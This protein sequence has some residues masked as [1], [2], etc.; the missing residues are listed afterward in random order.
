MSREIGTIKDSGSRGVDL[1][2]TRYYGG[3]K[4][5][6]CL[7][8]TAIKENGEYGCIQISAADAI[9]IL[10]EIKSLI[11]DELSHKRREALKAIEENRELEKS[12]VKDMHEVCSMALA[13]PV[14]N[15][16]ALLTLGGKSIERGDN[17]S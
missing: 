15:V 6:Q 9:A 1:H 7:Q 17:E 16:A 14:L 10:P 2:I 11:D 13:Q 8:L 4:R 12:I 5:G 3:N